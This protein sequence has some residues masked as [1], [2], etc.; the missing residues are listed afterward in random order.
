MI[1][2]GPKNSND[3]EAKGV[4][5]SPTSINNKCTETNLPMHGS[6]TPPL[7]D[8]L[9]Q[10][11]ANSNKI[12]GKRLR[13][14]IEAKESSSE[15]ENSGSLTKVQKTDENSGSKPVCKSKDTQQSKG[16]LTH[17][18]TFKNLP[19]RYDPLL[20]FHDQSRFLLKMELIYRLAKRHF[21]ER[22]I[23]TPNGKA[24]SALSFAEGSIPVSNPDHRL[25]PY[26]TQYASRQ[27]QMWGTGAGG[28]VVRTSQPES[29]E[30]LM[31]TI[32]TLVVGARS[33]MALGVPGYDVNRIQ[34]IEIF[35]KFGFLF[36]RAMP[37]LTKKEEKLWSVVVEET[38]QYKQNTKNS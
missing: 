10:D 30:K 13:V 29:V 37:P 25:L 26:Q 20:S 27:W 18:N 35:A 28:F 9:D 16:L 12:Y 36:Q 21:T 24:Y 2:I 34:W 15:E 11:H 1:Q 23:T 32:K 5:E 7:N 22:F 8:Y 38:K 19:T 31:H 14:L 4:W 33:K 17:E 6:A 3:F